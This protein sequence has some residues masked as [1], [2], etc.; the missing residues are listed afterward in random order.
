LVIGIIFGTID[1]FGET[2][3]ATPIP[4]ATPADATTHSGGIANLTFFDMTAKDERANP[5][6]E[7]GME[8]GTSIPS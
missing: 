4:T 3:G 7:T 6:V 5:L 1:G 8:I 2:I